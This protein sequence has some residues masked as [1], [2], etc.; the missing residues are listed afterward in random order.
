MSLKPSEVLALL[1]KGESDTVEFKESF[2][3]QVIETLAA[4]ANTK[5]GS[6]LLGVSDSGEVAGIEVG[7]ESAQNWTNQIKQS[8][9]NALFPDGESLRVKRK[10]IFVLSV[11]EHPIKP[12][13]CRGRYF[14]RVKNSNHQMTL[15]EVVDA[16]LKTFNTS[17]DYT[18]DDSHTVEDISIDK[19]L[20]FAE[21]IRTT[22]DSL[23]FEDPLT[24][25]RKFEILRDGGITRAGFLLFAAGET[26]FTT[27]ELGRFQ[28]PTLI[29]DGAR[30]KTDLISEVDG[31]MAFIKK[32]INKAYVITGAPQREERWDYPLEALREIVINAIVH[33]EYASS[34]DSI[35][36]IFDD[37]LEVFNP[38]LL[39]PNLTVEKL[40]SGQYVSTVRN[41]KIADIFKE[42]GLIEKYGT[43]VRRILDGFRNHGLP[44]PIFEEIS[45]GF[46]VTAY[47]DV[48]A[49]EIAKSEAQSATQAATQVTTQSTAQDTTQAPDNMRR[50]LDACKE[51]ATMEELMKRTG[52]RSRKHFRTA[53]LRRA[54]ENGLI[55][56]THPDKPRSPLQRYRLTDRGKETVGSISR[57]MVLQP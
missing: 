31:V 14:K 6:V 55:E 8:T 38:G 5:G 26:S 48:E 16:H 24:L 32:H 29:K 44:T 53:I 41:R 1:R 52:Y 39:P 17:W 15:S 50:L 37:R 51:P 30:L 13:A 25:L 4:F 12:V 49:A 11:P 19:V 43:G 36:K 54:M 35:V 3:R 46:R 40:L 22:H 23:S 27:I 7:K 21:R 33:R 10:P 20:A 2:D 34:S 47:R 28:T 45:G 57:E 18:I 9:G 56:Q 42:A